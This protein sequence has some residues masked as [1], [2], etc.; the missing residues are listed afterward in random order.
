MS[1]VVDRLDSVGT[2]IPMNNTTS[3]AAALQT[4][5]E[6]GDKVFLQ[7]GVTCGSERGEIVAKH[8]GRFGTSWDVVLPC[9]SIDSITGYVGRTSCGS[10]DAIGAYL[11]A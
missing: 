8:V 11:D 4:T 10:S 9:G 6:V 5:P 1:I 2:L 3:T 7:Y